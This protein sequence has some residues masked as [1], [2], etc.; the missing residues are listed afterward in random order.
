M[1]IFRLMG[2]SNRYWPPIAA[3]LLLLAV[4]TTG[5]TYNPSNFTVSNKPYGSSQAFSTDARS[6]MYDQTNFLWRDY[7]GTAEVLSYLNLPKYRYG[8]FPIYVHNGGILLPNGVWTGGTTQVYWFK[9]STGDANLVRWYTDSSTVSCPGCLLAVNNLS[10]VSNPTT[11]RGN[12]GLGSIAT[13]SSTASGGDL[14]GV[15]PANTVSR[16]NGQLPSYYL[17]YNNLTNQPAIPAQLNPTAAGLVSITGTY[18]NLTFSGNTPTFEQ[19][20]ASGNSLSANRTLN[21]G[22]WNFVFSGTAAIGLPTGTTAQRP[23]SPGTGYIRYNTDSLNTET[24]N[25][26]AWIKAGSGGGGGGSGITALTGDVSASGSGSVVATLATVNSNVFASNTFLKFGVN[27]KGLVTSATA[28]LSSD[29]ISALGY[30]PYN[31]TNPSGYISLSSLSANTPLTYN[32]GTGNF[33]IQ[34][35]NGSQNGYISSTDW[36]TFN[37]KQAALSNIGAGFRWFVPGSSI[38]TFFGFSGFVIDSTT[39]ANGITIGTSVNGLLAGNGT[40]TATAAT[41]NAPLTFSAGALSITQATTSTNGYLSSADW[42]TF[43][44]KGSVSSVGL[45]MPAMFTVTGSPVTTTGTLTASLANQSAYTGF[46]NWTNSSAAPTFS[47][48]PYQAFA[49]GTA[50]Y[51]NGYDGSG[52]PTILPPD[53]LFVKKIGT[54]DSLIYISS[55]TLY[56]YAI[57]DSANFHHYKNASGGYTFYSTGSG[58]GGGTVTQF[59]F[60]NGGGINGSVTNA[61]TTPTLGLTPSFTGIVQAASGT[62]FSAATIGAGLS[63][64]GGTLSSTAATSVF[65]RNDSLFYV[66]PS[67]NNYIARD[68]VQWGLAKDTVVLA[69]T[70]SARNDANSVVMLPD[71][72]LMIAYSGFGTHVGDQDTAAILVRRSYD[73]GRTWGAIDTAVKISATGANEIPSLYVKNN[74][75]V[76]M[77]YLSKNNS[78]VTGSINMVTLAAPYTPGTWSA[79]TTIY[80]PGFYQAPAGDRILK[81]QSG[82]LLYATCYSTTTDHGSAAGN[83]YTKI[84]KSLDDGNTWA[85]Q[86]Y[87]IASPDSIAVEPGLFQID[88]GTLCGYWRGRSG[89]VY[90]SQSVDTA[91]SFSTAFPTNL[92][93]TNATTS[94]KYSQKYKRLFAVHNKH[95]PSSADA[96]NGNG[97]RYAMQL[98]VSPN[99]G[100]DWYRGAYIDSVSGGAYVFEPSIFFDT[101]TNEILCTYSVFNGSGSLCNLQNVRVPNYHL[102]ANSDVHELNSLLLTPSYLRPY[103]T[104]AGALP[105]YGQQ[106]LR[107]FIATQKEIGYTNTVTAGANGDYFALSQYNSSAGHFAPKFESRSFTTLA[108]LVFEPTSKAEGGNGVVLFAPI[109]SAATGTSGFFQGATKT[110]SV[111]NNY[112]I[113]RSFSVLGSGA[114]QAAVSNATTYFNLYNSGLGPSSSFFHIDNVTGGNTAFSPWFRMQGNNSSFGFLWDANTSSTTPNSSFWIDANSSLS[115]IANSSSLFRVDNNSNH[116]VGST[117]KVRLQ[118]LGDGRLGINTLA[119]A[120]FLTVQGNTTGA[121]LANGWRSSFLPGTYMDNTTGVGNTIRYVASDY[122]DADSF[123]SSNA[124]T[125]SNLANGYFKGNQKIGGSLTVSHKWGV[126][127]DS[128]DLYINGNLNLKPLQ[129]GTTNDSL[130]VIRPGDSTVRWISPSRITGTPVNI[131]NSDGTLTSGRILN[132][133]GSA[134]SLTFTSLGTFGVSANAISLSGMLGLSSTGSSN[135]SFTWPSNK[136]SQILSGGLTADQTVTMP[137]ATQGGILTVINNNVPTNG[138]K[139]LISGTVQDASG[140]T[141]GSF[142]N[143]I[144]Y[145]LQGD[146]IGGAWRIIGQSAQG[147]VTESAAGTMT[148]AYFSTYVFTSTTATWTLPSLA[149]NPSRVYNIINAGSGNLTVQTSGSDNIWTAGSTSTSITIAAGSSRRVTAGTTNWWSQ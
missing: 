116:V 2:L 142:Q 63:F 117:T 96:I 124:I 58:G 24:W 145:I 1:K 114:I 72:S 76:L 31:A 19:V 111:T 84:L 50:G 62:S 41:I 6:M 127:I 69:T 78:L 136:T 67:G 47:K 129:S 35:G 16:F 115:N 43:N 25:G 121:Q 112:D 141:L 52:N 9:D 88:D 113:G 17:N 146:A 68:S 130:L 86:S 119:P 53:T 147:L 23:S 42:N 90:F 137:A 149:G 92:Y 7:N 61:T 45:S 11:A 134:F 60:T 21:S 123:A 108:G 37:T 57:T 89:F 73:H 14:S 33:T 64:S 18:P 94:I 122:H 97:G 70:T 100:T 28:V 80:N 132:G 82:S 133:S 77:L 118:L 71:G 44:N 135:T 12:L 81:T 65:K 131:Y 4:N 32:S 3:I 56:N 49:T 79:A 104:R 59:N 74:G 5:Q 13:L 38:R 139:W 107:F 91:N 34:V 126:M 83:Y 75:T 30:T 27:G 140:N 106:G 144:N 54:G 93:A 20:L 101:V 110:F 99:L 109:D 87:Q 29:I 138:F 128:G 85:A 103:T 148:L 105:P 36:T 40:G 46:G 26:S 22:I 102:I 39:N 8:H 95:D 55:D 10:D 143:G 51:L 15:W 125:Y 120:A 66:N 98:S 48:I